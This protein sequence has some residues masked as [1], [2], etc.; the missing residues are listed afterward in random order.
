[1]THRTYDE[2][3]ALFAAQDA[4]A[5]SA[6]LI[7]LGVSEGTIRQRL[8]TGEW[9]RA[10]RGVVGLAGVATTWRRQ[11]RT[12]LLVAGPDVALGD[13]S[14]GRQHG[15]DGYERDGRLSL[16]SIG[17]SKVVAPPGVRLR[18]ARGLTD[19]DVLD[20]DGLRCVSRPIALFGIAALDGRD[21]A[22]RALDSMLRERDSA[23][24]IAHVAHR[25]RRQGMS[26]PPIVLDLLHERV[27]GRLPRSW[28]QRLAKRAL[29]GRDIR[30]VDELPVGT[31]T[32][33][34][35]AHLDLAIPALQI[36]VECQSWR[37]HATPAARAAD[38]RRRR[39]LKRMGWEIVEVWW[40][41]LDHLDEVVDELRTIIDRRSKGILW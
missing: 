41:D 32:G 24:W 33:E 11:A 22:A 16:W 28:F 17:A 14:A 7:E 36:G 2:V 35:V 4:L 19:A 29:D 23:T 27:D 25:F 26:G 34:F 12:A 5:R 31:P 6:Q 18:R 40:S 39:R 13:V 38:A 30:T 8:R 10:G 1:M 3:A 37:W 21:A 9:E 15:M 20:V